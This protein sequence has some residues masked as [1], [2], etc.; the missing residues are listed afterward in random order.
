MEAPEVSSYS[1]YL[2][3]HGLRMAVR[4]GLEWTGMFEGPAG[5]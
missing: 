1:L 2:Q 3:S 4:R 5:F